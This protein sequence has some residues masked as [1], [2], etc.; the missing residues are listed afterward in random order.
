MS[1]RRVMSTPGAADPVHRSRCALAIMLKVP[2]QGYVKT[3]LVPPL[4]PHAAADLS[5]CMIRDTADNV[6]D[7]CR[8]RQAVGV[9]VYTPADAD[10]ALDALVPAAFLR[11]AQRDGSF[12][13]RLAHAAADLFATG[14]SGVCLIDSDSPTLPTATLVAAIGHLAENGDRLVIA[15]AEDGGYCLIGL[16][17]PHPEVFDQID[18]STSSVRSQTL[19]RAAAAGISVR[20]LARWFDVDDRE[21]LGRLCQELFSAS[22]GA[23]REG[24]PAPHT[25][26]F[27]VSL[28][29]QQGEIGDWRA[30]VEADAG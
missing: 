12:G 15:G 20:E 3:R 1:S 4:T 6:A 13:E 2:R 16:K 8:G 14:F 30:G 24:Y 28:A 17:A 5:R 10:A 29:D 11:L 7:A 23:G 27:L 26:Q 9:A 18:W 21:S 19:E 22:S 25:R